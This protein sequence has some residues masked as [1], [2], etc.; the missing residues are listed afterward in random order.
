MLYD[1]QKKPKTD[2][3]KESFAGVPKVVF[4]DGEYKTIREDEPGETCLVTV[5]ESGQ[6]T[7]LYTNFISFEEVRANSAK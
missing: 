5:F 3:S 2:P 4:E 1:V 6:F 7:G